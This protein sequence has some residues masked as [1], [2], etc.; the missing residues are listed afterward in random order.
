MVL[1]LRS[2]AANQLLAVALEVPG[3]P[4]IAMA[5]PEK[6]PLRARL[7]APRCEK[8]SSAR[9]ISSYDW[10]RPKRL[11]RLKRSSVDMILLLPN[12]LYGCADGCAKRFLILWIFKY[13]S[14]L[15]TAKRRVNDGP[16]YPVDL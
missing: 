10:E 6:Q 7:A 15:Q 9:P 5:A 4:C 12:N 2:T 8:A 3:G 13:H 11:K 1:R 16:S 14:D